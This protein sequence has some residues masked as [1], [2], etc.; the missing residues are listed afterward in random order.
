[1][2]LSFNKVLLNINDYLEERTGSSIQQM[3]K[4]IIENS[5]FDKKK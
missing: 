5:E 4:N 3:C 2:V 1:M